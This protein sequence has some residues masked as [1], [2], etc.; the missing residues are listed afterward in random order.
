V[1]RITQIVEDLGHRIVTHEF[2]D[3]LFARVVDEKPK[4][5]FNLASIYE[6]EKSDY[7]PAILEIASARYTGSGFLTLTLGRNPTKLLPML[8]NSGIPIPPY[9]IVHA[10]E[11]NAEETLQFPLEIWRNEHRTESVISSQGELKTAR[12]SLP[13]QEEIALRE[14]RKGRHTKVYILDSKIL[15][16]NLNPEIRELA[17]SAYGL[18]EARGLTGFDFVH[19][20]KLYLAGIDAAPDPLERTLLAAATS[21]GLGEADVIRKMIELASSD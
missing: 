15:P 18:I 20:E 1:E 7:I 10:E 6:W 21:A 11:M 2:D 17:L 16:L 13:P 9:R 12:R 8:D 3:T 19:A 14:C 4:V 5:V